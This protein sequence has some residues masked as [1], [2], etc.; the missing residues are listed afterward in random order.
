[1]EAALRR[2]GAALRSTSGLELADVLLRTRFAGQLRDLAVAAPT[3]RI[4]PL[5]SPHDAIVACKTSQSHRFEVP[6]LSAGPVVIL[7]STALPYF[8]RTVFHMTTLSRAMLNSVFIIE[9]LQ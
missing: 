4:A 2:G 8:K 9:F 3:R 7:R 6:C 1:M 5:D